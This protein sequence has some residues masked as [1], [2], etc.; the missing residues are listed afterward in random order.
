FTDNPS[1]H[2]SAVQYL[3]LSAA[4]RGQIDKQKWRTAY[5]AA[6]VDRMRPDEYW[7]LGSLTELALLGTLIDETTD[8]TAAFYL[9]QMQQRFKQV[10]AEHPN[11]DKPFQS[12]ELQLRRYVEWWLPD[13]GFF[14]GT[15]GLA[16]EA[17]Q[18]IPLC[19]EE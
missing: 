11:D 12:T 5:R 8:E 6:E 7:A 15:P 18:L 13:N 19:Q 2:W 3:A 10:Q 1:H 16:D 9:Q 14:P 17:R 4:L